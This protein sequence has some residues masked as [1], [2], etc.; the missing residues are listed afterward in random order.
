M[1]CYVCI[2]QIN[3]TTIMS[4]KISNKSLL[5]AGALAISIAASGA[6]YSA[7]LPAVSTCSFAPDSQIRCFTTSSGAEL[8]IASVHDEI[9]SYGV[10][11][12]EHYIG[13]GYTELT[14]FSQ[15]LGSGNLQKLFSY[16]NS[17]NSDFPDAT[18]DTNGGS[19]FDDYWPKSTTVTIADLKSYIGGSNTP[20]FGFDFLE[21]QNGPNKD[22][23]VTAYFEVKDASG[24]SLN[25]P[26]AIFAYDN[27]FDGVATAAAWVTAQVKQT[28]YWKDTSTCAANT[29]YVCSDEISNLTGGGAADVYAYA[30]GFNVNDYADDYT[31]T[32][33]LRLAGQDAGGE[34]LFLD[35]R[36]TPP[37][38]VPEPGSLALLGLGMF[39]LSFLRGRKLKG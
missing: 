18:L 6:A 11:A 5:K 4:R 8:Y 14:S 7:S 16:N 17:T 31:L 34:E 35:D 1:Y 38:Q 15:G 13:L 20:I 3:R 21:P 36:V 19:T 23:L 37:T 26:N 32:F 25:T 12:I 29:G 24:N 30:P 33:T 22:L 9:I 39:G 2:K 10:A 28:I 27:A